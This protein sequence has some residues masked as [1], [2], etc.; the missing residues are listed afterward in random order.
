MPSRQCQK[1]KAITAKMIEWVEEELK[2]MGHEVE[3][4]LPSRQRNERLHGLYEV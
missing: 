3:N 2:E 4:H 1:K